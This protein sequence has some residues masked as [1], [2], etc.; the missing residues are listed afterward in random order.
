MV[1]IFRSL[2]LQFGWCVL[3]DPEEDPAVLIK[4]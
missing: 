1:T 2:G 4:S 3:P